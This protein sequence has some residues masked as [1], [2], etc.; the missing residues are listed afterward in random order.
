MVT[1]SVTMGSMAERWRG[2]VT[3]G[4]VYWKS[5]PTLEAEAME[6]IEA[7][8]SIGGGTGDSAAVGAIAPSF[9]LFSPGLAAAE[10]LTKK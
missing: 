5:S 7:E 3:L 8:A 10:A 4:T 1:S 9:D 2:K 6:E